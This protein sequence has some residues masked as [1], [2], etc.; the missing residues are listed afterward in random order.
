MIKSHRLPNGDAYYEVDGQMFMDRDEA[1]R[2]EKLNHRA[3]Q[4]SNRGLTITGTLPNG[5]ISSSSGGYS[6]SSVPHTGASPMFDTYQQ[7]IKRLESEIESRDKEI[8]HLKEEAEELIREHGR[9][10]RECVLAEERARGLEVQVEAWQ[11]DSSERELEAR[12]YA[13]ILD[14]VV[15]WYKALPTPLSSEDFS[16][17]VKLQKILSKWDDLG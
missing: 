4:I 9:T 8:E 1:I 2:A 16:N 3:N 12:E 15:D 17:L 6:I 14:E 11:D 13:K 5:V 10:E 7:Q